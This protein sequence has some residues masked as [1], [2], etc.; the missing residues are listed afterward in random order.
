MQPRSLILVTVD[1]LR[2][3][4]VGFLGYTRPTTP[5]LDCLSQDG[6]V[7]ENAIA[8]GSP[9][10]YAMPPMLASRYPLALGRDLIGIA[11]EESTLATVLQESGFTT[12]AF[13]AANP[14]VSARF[15]YD[16]GFEVFADFLQG[17]GSLPVEEVP[18]N[19]LRTRANR[20]VSQACHSVGFLGAA[21]D[22]I[23][24]QYCQ[25]AG[26]RRNATLD[27]QRRFPSADIVVDRA[28][29]WLRQNS[30]RRFFLWIHLMDAHGPYFP[31]AEALK[32]L[33]SGEI[34]AREAI[35]LNSYW[36]REDLNGGRLIR[37]REPVISLYDAGIRW[38]DE[39]VRRLAESLVEMNAWGNCAL[40]VT[41]DHGE[42]FLDH[43]GRY[44]VPRKLT[45]ELIRVP[46]LM[47]VPGEKSGRVSNPFSILDLA[48]TLLDVV[49]VPSPA[50]FRGRSIWGQMRKGT[51][52]EKPVVSECV[53]EC[54][55]PFYP[56]GRIGPRLL[57]V[58]L[59]RFKLALDF[60][61][62]TDALY[63]LAEDPGET[64]P[65]NSD[66]AA[67]VRKKLLEVARK[68]LVESSQSRDFDRCIASKLRDY[69]LELARSAAHTLEN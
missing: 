49:G 64:R 47:R 9:T 8:A 12:A 19:G 58:R 52:Q 55:N 44:H 38:V 17:G 35:Y 65:L 56:A 7:F 30:A 66:E 24:F 43:G 31:K 60:A 27:T 40:A 51:F 2:A 53:Y 14:Y 22:E 13:S 59:G 10:Y 46:L 54:R 57:S 69:R 63:N 32:L 29:D 41:A 23:Y 36:N 34:D 3:D 1:C 26:A 28:I 11:P 20:L 21:Y 50:D 37:K 48:P 5:F 4:H 18:V 42:E 25:K 61:S 16:Q 39:Q 6:T 45:E 15:G 68:H 67:D 62:G 33:G